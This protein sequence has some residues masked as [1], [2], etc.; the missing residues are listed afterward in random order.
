MRFILVLLAMLLSTVTHAEPSLQAQAAQLKQEVVELNREIYE[1]EESLLF[2]ADTQLVVYVAMDS[3][4]PFELDGVEL[5]VDETPVTSY[6]YSDRELQALKQGGIQ[7][8]YMGNVAAGPHTIVA[9]FNGRGQGNRYMRKAARL[10]IDKG[11][12]AKYIELRVRS[13]GRSAAVPDFVVRDM[14]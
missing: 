2:P 10:R 11:A 4:A 12:D 5:T 7:R 3:D 6:L 8:L 9:V 1:L 13:S 14:K